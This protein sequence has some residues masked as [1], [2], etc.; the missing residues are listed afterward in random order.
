M[1]ILDDYTRLVLHTLLKKEVEFIVVGGYA[2][3]YYGFRRTTGD[4]DIWIK[5]DN[6]ITKPKLID[7]YKEI[8]ISEKSL[9]GIKNLDFSK[10]LVFKDGQVPY[11]IDFL[12]EIS[13]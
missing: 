7:A 12:T 10:T 5:P 1:N 13:W 4:I 8:G 2:V 6:F 3:N 9:E 11:R